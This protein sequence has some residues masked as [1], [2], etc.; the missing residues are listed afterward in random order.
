MAP[1][2]H[3]VLGGGDWAASSGPS[4]W[5]PSAGC[6]PGLKHAFVPPAPGTGSRPG[7]GFPDSLPWE[8]RSEQLP[9][10]LSA[11]PSFRVAGMGGCAGRGVPFQPRRAL[12]SRQPGQPAERGGRRGTG[13]SLPPGPLGLPRGWCR[14]ASQQAVPPA[15]CLARQPHCAPQT[16]SQALLRALAAAVARGRRW[17]TSIAGA[18]RLRSC[19]RGR[20][21]AGRRGLG[22]KVGPGHPSCHAAT[23]WHPLT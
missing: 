21:G 5:G 19:A 20:P 10:L 14:A 4:P 12:L 22:P 3:S 2:F 7:L 17:A 8:R 6:R 9:T 23:C 13:L 15:L 18:G 1:T 16:A 11:R